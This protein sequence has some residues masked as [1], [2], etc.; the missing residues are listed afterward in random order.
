MNSSDCKLFPLLKFSESK[1]KL[2]CEIK[3]IIFTSGI[4]SLTVT[5]FKYFPCAPILRLNIFFYY[6][7]SR[8]LVST[9]L[10][11]ANQCTALIALAIYATNFYSDRIKN[12]LFQAFPRIQNDNEFQTN[13]NFLQ[14][15][16]K[17]MEVFQFLL[18]SWLWKLCLMTLFAIR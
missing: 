13:E 2:H 9:S 14:V 5:Q 8:I 11:P 12:K 1:S 6:K 18:K 4:T 3:I 7:F 16:C 10:R 17:K 15:A